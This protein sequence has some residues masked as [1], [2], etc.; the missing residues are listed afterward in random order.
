MK[1]LNELEVWQ[2]DNGIDYRQSHRLL[3]AFVRH[4]N[5]VREA[6]LFMTAVTQAAIDAFVAEP[7]DPN[8]TRLIDT[9]FTRRN[10]RCNR[11]DIAPVPDQSRI[12]NLIEAATSASREVENAEA[13][14][15]RQAEI[16]A[17]Q[18]KATEYIR[19]AN[20]KSVRDQEQREALASTIFGV[21]GS[22]VSPDKTTES[23]PLLTAMPPPSHA[24]RLGG[25][26]GL[27]KPAPLPPKVTNG[28]GKV[29]DYKPPVSRSQAKRESIQRSIAV[30]ARG[31]APL[32]IDD[33]GPEEEIRP[34]SQ[35][36]VAR[37]AEEMREF[38]RK[39]QG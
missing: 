21:N 25:G 20:H 28:S 36:E 10:K 31:Y 23:K 29:V 2:R 15:V 12:D 19:E 9:A 4:K 26:D 27:I 18:T 16:V 22:G 33:D 37:V 13:Q 3:M 7:E 6:R 32:P 17:E 30:A 38:A 34:A 5:L 39:Q 11:G 35:S 24:V 8:G 14:K 1:K